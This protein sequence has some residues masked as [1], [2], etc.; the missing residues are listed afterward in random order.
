MRVALVHELPDYCAPA[1]RTIRTIDMP[2]GPF[3]TLAIATP[4]LPPFQYEFTPEDVV[5]TA[6]LIWG[7]AGGQDDPD[8]LAVIRAMLNHY[9]FFTHQDYSTFHE[10]IRA[11]ATSLQP[12]LRDWR[13]ARRYMHRSGFVWHDGYYSPPYEENIP[14]GQLQR[15]LNI[16]RT[17]WSELPEEAK[18]LVERVM[19]GEDNANPIGSASDFFSTYNLLKHRLKEEGDL[20]EPTDEEWHEFTE[21]FKRDQHYQWIGPV[22]NLNQKKN[23]FFVRTLLIPGDPME[24]RYSDLPPDTVRVVPSSESP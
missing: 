23:A 18:S 2:Q 5:W 22:P 1:I 19:K 11:Y 7:E 20:R 10:F 9:A 6:R 8:N 13:I 3:G 16:Q 24:R 4:E 15:H 14:R 21:N 17:P 12:V